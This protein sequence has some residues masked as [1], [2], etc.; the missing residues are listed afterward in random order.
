M[1]IRELWTYTT[2]DSV[3]S[4]PTVVDGTV[5]V[6][7]NDDNLYALD[8]NDGSE[9]WRYTIDE[10]SGSV[11]RIVSSPAVAD[12]TVYVPSKNSN[13]YAI[14]ISDGSEE[15]RYDDDEHSSMRGTVLV[16]G[17]I[18]AIADPFGESTVRALDASDVSEEWSYD[19][20][21]TVGDEVPEVDGLSGS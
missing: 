12:G 6:G 11:N 7:S 17:T 10:G 4:S 19:T 15:W 18:Y 2:D 16:D 8:A 1:L 5:Y 3:W 21:V 9:E 13:L 20:G 14:D